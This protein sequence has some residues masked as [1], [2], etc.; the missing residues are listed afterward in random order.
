MDIIDNYSMHNIFTEVTAMKGMNTTLILNEPD[1]QKHNILKTHLQESCAKHG[2]PNAK[3]D[4]IVENGLGLFEIGGSDNYVFPLGDY[5]TIYEYILS[6]RGGHDVVQA[7]ESKLTKKQ[8]YN[9][10]VKA[11]ETGNRMAEY[12]RLKNLYS[13]LA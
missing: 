1:D 8:L 12:R 13:A 9:R 7:E 5:A 3:K 4:L 10:L 6:H 11:A 2:V